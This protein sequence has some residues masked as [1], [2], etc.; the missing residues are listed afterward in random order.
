MFV[1]GLRHGL[2]PDHIAVI[3]NI[4]FRAVDERPRLSAWIGSLFALGHS[5]AVAGVAIG[6]A[7]LADR[8]TP[9]AWLG[10]L[11]DTV[12]VALLVLVGTL[13]LVALRRP[14]TYVPIGWRA[15]LVPVPLRNSTHPAAV[16]VIGVVFGLVFDTATQAAAWGAA[17]T[18]AGGI[19]AAAGIALAFAVGMLV[20][21]TCDSQIVSRLLR[22][23]RNGGAGVQRYR[24]AVG[25]MIVGLSYSMAL[26]AA[27]TA[28][29]ADLA[30]GDM[31]FKM[32]GISTAGAVILA[33]VLARLTG[34]RASRSA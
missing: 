16:V 10:G 4:V 34:E 33:L 26:F 11:V 23:T 18:S 8:I 3:D 12:V 5:V 9:P 32:I 14:G 1:L 28:S 30:I 29:G 25:W 2:D 24:R 17:A 21:D 19:V 13:N 27:L 31:T 15:R 6:V 20:S 7:A 22:A